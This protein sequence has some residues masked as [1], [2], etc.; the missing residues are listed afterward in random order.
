MTT[1]GVFSFLLVAILMLCFHLMMTRKKREYA[2][3][4]AGRRRGEWMRGDTA[5]ARIYRG[6]I[7]MGLVLTVIRLLYSICEIVNGC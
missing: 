3:G 4:E 6:I 7:W 2:K 1:E 5:S